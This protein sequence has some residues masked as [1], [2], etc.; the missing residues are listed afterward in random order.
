M[1]ID[2]LGSEGNAR[3]DSAAAKAG[4]SHGAPGKQTLTMGVSP[5]PPPVQMKAGGEA[6]ASPEQT[7]EIAERGVQGASQALPHG[8]TIQRLF[9]RHDVSGVK[10]Q[11]GGPATEANERLGA[12]AYATGN[13]IGFRDQPDLHTAAHEA[14]HVVQQRSGV[15][16]SG[17]IGA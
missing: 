2:R 15:S 16:L 4:V 5:E 6:S 13:T 11:V 14:A 9:G 17:G 7:H 10:A 3:S 12:N 1:T 8:E